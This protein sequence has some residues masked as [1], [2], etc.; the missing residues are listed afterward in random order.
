[1]NITEALNNLQALTTDHLAYLWTETNTRACAT[2]ARA[3]VT[4]WCNA[5]ATVSDE[6]SRRGY[7]LRVVGG[8]RYA[9][10]T[11]VAARIDRG[12]PWL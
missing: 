4:R 12:E 9:V 7:T 10:K 11:E 1:M 3:W 5:R 8:Y 2:T 6:L